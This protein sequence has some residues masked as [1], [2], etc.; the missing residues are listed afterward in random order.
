MITQPYIAKCVIFHCV[1]YSIN[2]LNNISSVNIYHFTTWWVLYKDFQIW[3]QTQAVMYSVV[4]QTWLIHVRLSSTKCVLRTSLVPPRKTVWV[5][6][7]SVCG[8]VRTKTLPLWFTW[9]NDPELKQIYLSYKQGT[10]REV[11]Q[12]LSFSSGHN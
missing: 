7:I 4:S 9:V 8:T 2:F 5:S 6:K 3:K 12:S 11:C 1:I 10:L